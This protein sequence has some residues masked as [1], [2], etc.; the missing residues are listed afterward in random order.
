MQEKM[1][2]KQSN[3][4]Q[5]VVVFEGRA[6]GWCVVIGC[7]AKGQCLMLVRSMHASPTNNGGVSCLYLLLL[8]WL[9]FVCLWSCVT[10]T[11]STSEKEEG[12]GVDLVNE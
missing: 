10:L 7:L 6:D 4:H 1:K 8:V 3:G 2:G 9:A 5:F 12:G 11:F